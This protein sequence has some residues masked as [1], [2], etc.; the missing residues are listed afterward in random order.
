VAPDAHQ[1]VFVET[2]SASI[3]CLATLQGAYVNRQHANVPVDLM[4]CTSR[5]V[6]L[7]DGQGHW[8]L[9]LTMVMRNELPAGDGYWVNVYQEGAKSYGTPMKCDL[10]GCNG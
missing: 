6:T 3:N 5:N 4:F 9:L 1:G 8:G 7:A 10:P 2:G